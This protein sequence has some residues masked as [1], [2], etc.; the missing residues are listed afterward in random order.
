[1]AGF[2][3]PPR[4]FRPIPKPLNDPI[5]VDAR[6]VP[7]EP[8][9]RVANTFVIRPSDDFVRDWRKRLLWESVQL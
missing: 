5:K 8:P 6:L 4:E 9:I 7:Y 3:W 2:G 1:M